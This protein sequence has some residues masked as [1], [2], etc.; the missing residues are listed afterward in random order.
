[1]DLRYSE[2][3]EVFRR[4][5]RGW[6]DEVIRMPN[7]RA[8]PAKAASRALATGLALWLRAFAITASCTRE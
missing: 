8:C 4:E 6:L 7:S 5:V 1:M 2:A 3:D